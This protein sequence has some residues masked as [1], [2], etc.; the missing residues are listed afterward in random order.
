MLWTLT[1]LTINVYIISASSWQINDGANAIGYVS[2][3]CFQQLTLL[4]KFNIYQN[5]ISEFFRLETTLIRIEIKY[6]LS[7]ISE[8]EEF[9]YD[10]EI[11]SESGFLGINDTLT[12]DH[13]YLNTL[14]NS[15]AWYKNLNNNG[16]RWRIF[17]EAFNKLSEKDALIIFYQPPVSPIWK[18]KTRNT[19]IS[20]TEEEYSNKLD[21]LCNQ[22]ENIVFYDFYNND[23]NSLGNN[24]YYDYQHLNRNG[25]EVFSEL[26][27][28]IIT[29]EINARSQ[30]NTYN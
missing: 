11:I 1:I 6:L 29:K 7:N 16:G 19:V 25:A 24:M 14:L 17:K 9:F 3:K 20:K 13:E 28:D 30:S 15:H 18:E 8:N 23:I 10:D 27:A 12:I 5:E 4:E 22:Y 21:S 2:Q 26:F